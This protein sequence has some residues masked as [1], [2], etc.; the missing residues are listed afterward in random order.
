MRIRNIINKLRL[1][2]DNFKY[3]NEVVEFWLDGFNGERRESEE[4]MKKAF[5]HIVRIY[6]KILYM[7]PNWHYFYEG[8][9]SLIRCSYKFAKLVIKYF[10]SNLIEFRF[11]SD[12]E[13]S[14]YVTHEYR[15]IFKQM[16]HTFSVLSI[17]MYKNGDDRYLMQAGDRVCHCFHNHA[18]YLANAVGKLNKYRRAHESIM[19]WEA[20]QMSILTAERCY[21][22]GRYQGERDMQARYKKREERENGDSQ[23]TGGYS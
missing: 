16:F 6:D 13:E 19:K 14:L 18:I 3:R 4:G 2:K 5:A 15:E 10:K 9:Y 8:E 12:W 11:R 1:M 17:E 20:D 22:N 23:S 7:D 21:Y